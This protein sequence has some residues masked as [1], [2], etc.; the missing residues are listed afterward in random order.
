MCALRPTPLS[1]EPLGQRLE[2]RSHPCCLFQPPPL[3]ASH[4]ARLSCRTLTATAVVCVYTGFMR[5][6]LCGPS[7]KACDTVELEN[8]SPNAPSIPHVPFTDSE[9]V[10]ITPLPSPAMLQSPHATQDL[11]LQKVFPDCTVRTDLVHHGLWRLLLASSL[12]QSC[13][14]T[15]RYLSAHLIAGPWVAKICWLDVMKSPSGDRPDPIK[16]YAG[17]LLAK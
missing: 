8:P 13:P 9:Q 15:C 11:L 10:Q 4:Q 14:S 17:C 5:D 3:I 1:W 6:Q 16:V 12:V 7:P 2:S